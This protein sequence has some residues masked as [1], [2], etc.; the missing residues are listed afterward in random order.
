MFDAGIA[1][2]SF[3]LAAWDKGI[4]TVIMGIFDEEKIAEAINLPQDETVAALIA[5]GYFDQTPAAPPR[6]SAEEI[7]RTIK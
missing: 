2:Q 4:G 7:T 6:K 5:T 3:C 1:A